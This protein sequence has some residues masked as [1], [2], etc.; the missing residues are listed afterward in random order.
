MLLTTV[1]AVK[2]HLSITT[3]NQDALIA[4]YIA[5]ETAAIELYTSR[6]FPRATY[7]RR[8]T[9]SGSSTLVLPVGPVLRVSS[10]SISG[11]AVPAAADDLHAGYLHDHLALHLTGGARWPAQLKNVAATW[12]TGYETTQDDV[13]PA[14]LTLTPTTGGRAALDNGV[15]LADGTVLAAVAG[16]PA[17]GQYAFADGTYTFHAAQQGAAVTLAYAYIPG[18][19]EQACIDLVSQDLKMRDNVGI[20]SKTLAGETIVYATDDFSRGVRQALDLYRQ[21]VP[22]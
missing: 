15:T 21:V 3:A 9:G 18:A 12:T 8:L 4:G 14:G 13:V 11:V 20:S 22:A 2:A 19:V 1:A 6:T 16:T 7:T 17:A 10:V 5:R